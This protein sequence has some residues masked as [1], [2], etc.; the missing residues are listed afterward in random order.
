[1]QT[2]TDARSAID[3]M[4]AVWT[5]RSA[6]TALMYDNLLNALRGAPALPGARCR[7]K[8]HLFDPPAP[9]EHPETTAQRHNQALGLCA[10]CPS[11]GACQDWVNGLPRGR[12]PL[13]ITA[14]LIRKPRVDT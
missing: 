9:R 12:R 7:G 4:I 8:P 1:M 13:G 2:L 10:L 14:G 6:M 5:E 3:A 11:L